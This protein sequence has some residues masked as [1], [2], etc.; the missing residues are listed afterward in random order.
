MS[1]PVIPTA[2][3]YRDLYGQNPV[4]LVDIRDALEAVDSQ[5]LEL[6]ARSGDKILDRS[7]YDDFSGPSHPGHTGCH[8]DC[9]TL[10]RLP[11]GT[12]VI[13]VLVTLQ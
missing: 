12:G 8:V 11:A 2:I 9:Q 3:G 1:D 5:V 10:E 6:Y 4:K 13:K 7:R